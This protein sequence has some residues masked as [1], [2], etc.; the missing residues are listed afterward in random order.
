MTSTSTKT[1]MVP[2][3]DVDEL[4]E[5]LAIK[6][7]ELLDTK[8]EIASLKREVDCWHKRAEC[9][10]REALKWKKTCDEWRHEWMKRSGAERGRL[11]RQP[12]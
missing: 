11:P 1:G 7:S 12:S 5:E 3:A 2:Q 8:L 9:A 6:S 4:L 10:E